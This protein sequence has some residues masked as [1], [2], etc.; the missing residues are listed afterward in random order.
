MG[1]STLGH[2]GCS[3]AKIARCYRLSISLSIF[4]KREEAGDEEGRDE[5]GEGMNGRSTLECHGC[6][7]AKIAGYKRSSQKG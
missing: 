6:S 7:Q 5:L 3:R 2:P 1:R 4:I